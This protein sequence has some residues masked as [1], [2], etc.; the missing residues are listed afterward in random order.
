MRAADPNATIDH[1]FEEDKG[2]PSE[3][4]T[5][6][7]VQ[8]LT[9]EERAFLKNL[10]GNEGTVT[11]YAIHLGIGAPRQFFDHKGNPIVFQRDEKAPVILGNKRPWKT[12]C[13]AY[14][15]PHV[16]DELA[17]LVLRGIDS[18]IEGAEAKNS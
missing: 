14:L 11:L 8:Q 15:L 6:F 9:V 18:G 2:L 5:I 17:T 7:P 4:Q 10:R 1:V 12:E 3:Q 16:M 13:L